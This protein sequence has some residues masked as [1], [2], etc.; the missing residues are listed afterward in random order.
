MNESIAAL[1]RKVWPS[2]VQIVVTSYGPREPRPGQTSVEVGRQ[3]GVGSGFVIDPD[4]YI[5]TNAHVVANAQRVQVLLPPASDDGSIATALSTKVNLVAAR[6]VGISTETRPR[7]AEDRQAATTGADPGVVL[8]RSPGRDG[9]RVREPLWPDANADA[10]AHLGCRAPD[11]IRTRRSSTCRPTR[12]STR[13]TRAGRSSTSVARSS[14]STRS[15]SRRLAAA[16][17]SASRFRAR[18]CAR[19]SG[20]S[21]STGSCGGRKWA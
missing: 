14:A 20:S 9:V 13:A 11:R 17:G 8:Q 12:R 2:V 1:T 19:R 4:G 3:R 6:I 5:M 10:R 18:R 16:T 7:V 21:S 15:S